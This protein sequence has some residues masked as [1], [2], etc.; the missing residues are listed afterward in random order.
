MCIGSRVVVGVGRSVGVI[1]GEGTILAIGAVLAVGMGE[2]DVEVIIGNGVVAGEQAAN[3]TVAT[4]NIIYA[5]F[6]LEFP[7]IIK[8]SGYDIKRFQI[9]ILNKYHESI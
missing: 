6:I 3:S 5:F 9:Q 7:R 8:Q 1:V 4:N 2:T